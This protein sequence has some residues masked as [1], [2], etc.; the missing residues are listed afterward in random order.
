M[1][2]RGRLG[3]TAFAVA[4]AVVALAAATESLAGQQLGRFSFSL[5]DTPV[6]D[7]LA[8]LV[9]A[10]GMELLYDAEVVRGRRTTCLAESEPA[11][12]VLRCIVTGA[13]LDFYRTSSGTYVVIA[14]PEGLPD[15]TSLTGIVV[16]E[17]S[18]RPIPFAAI[19]TGDRARRVSANAA[20]VFTLAGMRPGE[21]ELVATSLGYRPARSLV[22]LESG[23][24]GRARISLAPVALSLDPIIVSGLGTRASDDEM[25][26]ASWTRS[27]ARSFATDGVLDTPVGNLGVRRAPLSSDLGIQGSSAGEYLVRLDGVPVFE[28]VSL[29]GVRSAFSGLAVDRVTIHKAGFGVNEGSF[30]GGV[31][32]VAQGGGWDAPLSEVEARVGPYDVEGSVLLPLPGVG[33]PGR[34]LVAGRT[35]VWDFWREPVLD[36]VLRDWNR[37]DPVLARSIGGGFASVADGLDYQPHRDGSDLAF[38]DLHL[39]SELPLGAFRRLEV[40]LYRGRSGVGTE[41]FSAGLRPGSGDLDRAVL[42]TDRY[43][44][45]N[46][47]GKVGFNTLLG[48]R[49]SARFAVRGS[50]YALD[51]TYATGAL[52]ASDP[53][54]VPADLQTIETE[55]RE[56]VS[57][58]VPGSDGNRITEWGAS[59]S[60]DYAA[61]GGHFLAGGLDLARV[62]SRVQL[63]DPYLR[64]LESDLEQTRVSGWLEDRVD[65][66]ERWRVEGGLRAT[67]LADRDGEAFLEPRLAVRYDDPSA[68]FGGW[69]LRVAT[70]VYHQFLNRYE[71]TNVGPSALVPAVQFWMP[72]DTSVAPMRAY[73]L[74]A[75]TVWRPSAT[76]EVRAEAYH[77][78]MDRILSLDYA[79]LVLHDGGALTAVSQSEFV[80]E[81]EGSA[82][83]FG[84]SVERRTD[85]LRAVAG[86]EFTASER[87]FPS[88]F[89]GEAQP[90][91]WLE[92][93]RLHLLADLDLGAGFRLRTEGTGVWGRSW[94]L[95][96]AYYDFM[97]LHDFG[98]PVLGDPE[99][100]VL[101]ALVQ[102]DVGAAWSGS[103][104]GSRVEVGLEIRN[105]IDRNNVLDQSLRRAVDGG[106]DRYMRMPRLLPGITPLLS[107]RIS[108]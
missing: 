71:V 67:W 97:T 85:R 79:A 35:S 74:S 68:G 56:V 60:A 61:G 84:V 47:L 32:D 40:S 25:G 77:K 29:G 92:P 45:S 43:D 48:E 24:P 99:G 63:D 14:G 2:A 46:T 37:P 101:P 55:L 44:W 103:L 51:H 49:T 11:E 20:G 95:R 89:G 70:G 6:D 78:V 64:R 53:L 16:D 5:R 33:A 7:A 105:A 36:G 62:S 104:G 65:L 28:P 59:A 108:P 57:Q 58:E 34:L 80:G 10:T 13:R 73:H 3:S 26:A 21:V 38:S 42:S 106:A 41:L 17:R 18:G 96:R 98:G 107:V 27:E 23:G 50:R 19:E 1:G 75:E 15:A 52:M 31:V 9:E 39:R 94:G 69:S 8:R 87:T 81:A 30:T 4:A 90:V 100:D 82:T 12:E 93:H 76:L 83:G 22:T 66:G 72:P 102:L 86:Y 54:D 91:P 88:R